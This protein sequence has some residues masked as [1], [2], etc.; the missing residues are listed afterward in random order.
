MEAE[1]LAKQEI[2]TKLQSKNVTK[3]P[4]KKRRTL[5]T[6]ALVEDWFRLESVTQGW[7]VQIKQRS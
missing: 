5:T 4:I 6:N 7:K 2:V 3:L 1:R